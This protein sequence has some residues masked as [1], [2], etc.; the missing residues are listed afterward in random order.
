MVRD[1]RYRVDKENMMKCVKVLKIVV[2]GY[3][4]IYRKNS[5]NAKC[6]TTKETI[7]CKKASKTR[8]CDYKEEQKSETTKA[9]SWSN[10]SS[11]CEVEDKVE[12]GLLF[13][14]CVS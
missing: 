1:N 4:G 8:V 14:D 5:V 13:K 11:K 9:H 12:Q 2:C 10:V 6:C 3:R 7:D